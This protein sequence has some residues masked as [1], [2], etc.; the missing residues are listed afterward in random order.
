MR[1]PEEIQQPAEKFWVEEAFADEDALRSYAGVIVDEVQK[2][3]QDWDIDG[4]EGWLAVYRCA[5]PRCREEP[6]AT[7]YEHSLLLITLSIASTHAAMGSFDTMYLLAEQILQL[8]SAGDE[9]RAKL[10]LKSRGNSEIRYHV[11]GILAE[12]KWQ[13]AEQDRNRVMSVED[14][15]ATFRQIADK[16]LSHIRKNPDYDDGRITEALSIMGVDVAAM[17]FRWLHKTNPSL[18]GSFVGWCNDRLEMCLA[19]EPGQCL[20]DT[21]QV[22][23]AG[24]WTYELV[25]MH[26]TRSLTKDAL[27]YCHSKRLGSALSI[28]SQPRHLTGLYGAWERQY[29][30][31]LA[32]IRESD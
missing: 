4:V 14:V 19:G 13:G 2:L 18:V 10:G 6:L 1:T 12:A 24:Y 25:K 3:C 29:N 28:L 5:E 26:F 17:L 21:Q 16:V 30:L 32:S 7:A 11:C 20:T 9:R 8:L 15:A 31:M 22:E 27:D 23:S